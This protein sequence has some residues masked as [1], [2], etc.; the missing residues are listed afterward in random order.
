M[1]KIFNTTSLSQKQRFSQAVLY[2][3]LASIG[4]T[5]VYFLISRLL[6]EGGIEFSF[7]FVAVGMA[8]GYVIQKTGHGVQLKFAI[9]ASVLCVLVILVGDALTVMPY[10]FSFFEALFVTPAYYLSIDINSLLSLAFRVIGVYCA[11]KY[12]RIV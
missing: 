7:T 2:G 12:S 10:G 6:L 4:L 1:L 3:S 9:L 8:I 11:F 5:V